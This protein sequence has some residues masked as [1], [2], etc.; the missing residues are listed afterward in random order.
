MKS[1]L[2]FVFFLFFSLT[3]FGQEIDRNAV[4]GLPQL[5]N[6]EM[7]GIDTPTTGSVVFNTNTLTIHYY[8][9]TNWISIDTGAPPVVLNAYLDFNQFIRNN[10]ISNIRYNRIRTNIGG[11][12]NVLR[13]RNSITVIPQD[14]I[15]EISHTATV[16]RFRSVTVDPDN[17]DN[18][19]NDVKNSSIN[20]ESNIQ[21]NG[22][23]I[24]GTRSITSN[25]DGLLFSVIHQSLIIR[26]NQN[27]E[28]SVII[29]R[30][31]GFDDYR[32]LGN[33]AQLS[34]KKID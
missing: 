3:I 33:G 8:D 4:I 1:N 25:E 23:T 6:D 24:P 12:P 28:I 19:D 9:G 18:P 20:F 16:E 2:F 13:N 10:E 17:P 34:I 22:T 21:L 5:T 14:G 31:R 26:L 27:D 15:Y 7:N 30:S 11:F 32:I 29:Q